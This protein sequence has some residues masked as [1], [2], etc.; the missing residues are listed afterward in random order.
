MTEGYTGADLFVDALEGYGVEHVFGN[1]G[2]TELPIMNALADSNMEY[3]LDPIPFERVHEQLRAR[4]S[5]GH[6][7]LC[8]CHR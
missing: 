2:T 4:V 5:F 7:S 6:G 8:R 1:P 3:V